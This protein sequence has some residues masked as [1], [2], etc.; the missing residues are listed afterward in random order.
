MLT[1]IE[2]NPENNGE[3]REKT[4]GKTRINPELRGNQPMETDK[5]IFK[6]QNDITYSRTFNRSNFRESKAIHEK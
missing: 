6:A 3:P 2:N 5:F 1:E 4:E